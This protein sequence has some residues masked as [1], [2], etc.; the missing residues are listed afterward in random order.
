MQSRQEALREAQEKETILL[1][2]VD[3]PFISFQVF[4]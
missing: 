1:A 3:F 4:I 2:Q